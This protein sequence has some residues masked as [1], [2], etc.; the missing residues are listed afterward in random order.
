MLHAGKRPE[1]GRRRAVREGQRDAAV[2]RTRALHE[3]GEA[4]IEPEY[5][6]L[7]DAATLTPV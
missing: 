3:L 7:V 6:E 2:I 5:F 4:Q 1:I